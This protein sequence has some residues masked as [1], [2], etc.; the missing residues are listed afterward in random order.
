M[1]TGAGKRRYKRI[2]TALPIRLW[3]MDANGRPFIEV[4]TTVNV[5]R[6]GTQVN[7]IPAKLSEGDIIGLRCGE[8]K[9][10]FRVVWT[11]KKGT[12][13]EGHV[14][15]QSLEQGKW[16]WD[17][18]R[19]PPDDIDIYARPPHLEQRMVKRL[20]SL[21]SAEI[22]SSEGPKQR[23]LAFVTNIGTG[24]CYVRMHYRLPV[25]TKVSIALW[26]DEQH[27]IWIDGIVVSSHPEIG[28]GIK[29]LNVTRRATEAIEQYIEIISQPDAAGVEL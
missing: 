1:S 10:N 17:G 20:Q 24:G 26:L 7:R 18:L 27:K 13:A 14:G 11:G 2:R 23:I 21:V 8:R 3:G 6:A 15:L 19:L 4:S 22:V 5:S 25:E 12:A 16:I 28:A 29:F 9:Y